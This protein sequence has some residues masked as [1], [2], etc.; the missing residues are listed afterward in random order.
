MLTT[1][2]GQVH[3]SDTWMGKNPCVRLASNQGFHEFRWVEFIC[4]SVVTCVLHFTEDLIFSDFFPLG[5][6]LISLDY[7][8][9]ATPKTIILPE[10]G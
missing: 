8:N 1:L 6:I 2:A 10:N 5:S 3:I 7:V 9:T 4:S